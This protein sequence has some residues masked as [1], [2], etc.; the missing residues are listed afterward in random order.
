VI[1]NT[2]KHIKNRALF[3]VIAIILLSLLL[4]TYVIIENNNTPT[5]QVVQTTTEKLVLP[6]QSTEAPNPAL[7]TRIKIPAI[8]VDAA[9]EY[10]GLTSDGDMAVPDD[11]INT[12]WYS[13]G[14]RPGENGSA[15]IAGH[16]GWVNDRRAVYDDLHKLRIGDEVHIETIKDSLTF[17]VSDIRMYGPDD[18]V[19]EVF[20]TK[21]SSRLNLITCGGAWS[22]TQQSYNQRLVV[23]TEKL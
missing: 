19:P 11:P 4:L 6:D 15:V 2:I 21:G 10:L 3:I 9:I 8:N 17:I 1:R 20:D 18:I 13:L 16:F 7:P 22:K 14:P 23:F 5:P 12:G